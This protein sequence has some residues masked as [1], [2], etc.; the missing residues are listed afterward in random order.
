MRDEEI[1]RQIKRLKKEK[2]AEEDTI[3]NEAW[4]YTEG[5]GRG[6]FKK[7]IKKIWREGK[8]PKEWYNGI[9]TAIWKTSNRK[10]V[11]NYIILNDRLIKEINEKNLLPDNQAG[12]RKDRSTMDNIYIQNHIVKRNLRG[13]EGRLVAFFV[14]LKN[15]LSME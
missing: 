8:I 3:P 7:A 6:S 14:D 12:F 11:S 10:V 9:T 2:T 13:R 4:I 1:E 5:R 15:R